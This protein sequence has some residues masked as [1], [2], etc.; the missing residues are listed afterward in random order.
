MKKSIGLAETLFRVAAKIASGDLKLS[1]GE[2]LSETGLFEPCSGMGNIFLAQ[3]CLRNPAGTDL[4]PEH[5]P[6]DLL[7]A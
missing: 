1:A 7:D 4:E 2:F 6:D 5:G 3:D